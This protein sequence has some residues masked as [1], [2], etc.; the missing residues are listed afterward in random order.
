MITNPYIGQRLSFSASLCTVRYIGPVQGTKN[1]WL[2]VE[3]DDPSRGKHEGK[4]EGVRY[5]ECK[6]QHPT[7]G[8]FVRPTRP[9]DP[10]LSYLEALQQKYAR[11]ST[12]SDG[13]LELSEVPKN[14]IKWGGKLVEEIGFEKIRTQLAMLQELRTVLLDGACI[15]GLL[16]NAQDEDYERRAVEREYIYATCPK[17]IELDLSRNLF[18]R[19]RD[20]IEICIQLEELRILRVNGNKFA[21]L[22]VDGIS[23]GGKVDATCGRIKELC[24]DDTSLSW[25]EITKTA[26][27]FIT[28]T[29]LSASFNNIPILSHHL[30]P[31]SITRLTLE[32]NRFSTLADLSPLTALSRLATLHLRDNSICEVGTSSKSDGTIQNL[33]FSTSLYY[34]D[35]SCNAIKSWTSIDRLQDVFPGLTDLRVAHNPLYEDALDGQA[36]GEEEGYMLTIARLGQLKSLNFSTIKLQERTNAEMYYLSRIARDLAD[37][38]EDQEG[39]VTVRHRRFVELSDLYG[40]PTIKRT[41]PSSINPN[42]LEARL[43]NFT[44]Y[45]ASTSPS[46]TEAEEIISKA[47]RIPKGFDIYRL[48]GIVGRLFGLRPLR[49]RLIWET[50]EWDPIAGYEEAMDSDDSD[51]EGAREWKSNDKWVK[52]E[53]E[54]EDGT[55]EVG[56]WVEGSEAKVRVELR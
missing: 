14:L 24:F 35:L 49:T 54:L 21:N 45:L 42:S 1:E 25:E 26:A 27:P 4:H 3:W 20:V 7:A 47:K 44:F 50:G 53:V 29:A 36:I 17:I 52:R 9:T 48:K 51:T 43:I 2:G 23:D 33:E 18:E 8:S 12:P 41:A 55:R 16:S 11:K 15:A 30:P 22:A 34:I 38:P 32:G 5:F 46:S 13:P 37:V 40:P 6:S 28:L 31:E 56:F 39:N 19:W 10:S